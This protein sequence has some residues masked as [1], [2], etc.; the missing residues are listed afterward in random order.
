MTRVWNWHLHHLD[1][2][3]YFVMSALLSVMLASLLMVGIAAGAV[4]L[5]T[6]NVQRVLTMAAHGLGLHDLALAFV[7][8]CV[9]VFFAI[10]GFHKLFV[11][12]RHQSLVNNLTKNKIPALKFMQ[13]WVPGWEFAAGVM[14]A[15]GLFTAFSAGVLAIICM[16]ACLCEAR[17]KVAKYNPINWADTIDDYLYL[18]EVLYLVMLAVSVMAGTGKYSVDAFLFPLQ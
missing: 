2:P 10:S 17:E 13:W 4:Q 12:A 6:V 15:I 16:V 8:G 3:L 1:S 18:P 5:S 9:G 11:P 7:R 14:L